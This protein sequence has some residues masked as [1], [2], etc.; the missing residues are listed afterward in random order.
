MVMLLLSYCLFC[1]MPGACDMYVYI[2]MDPYL[3][4]CFYLL[5]RPRYVIHCSLCFALS[6]QGNQSFPLHVHGKPSDGL[7][8]VT[9]FYVTPVGLEGERTCSAC[10]CLY[11]HTKCMRVCMCVCLP[12]HHFNMQESPLDSLPWKPSFT[13]WPTCYRMRGAPTTWFMDRGNW[14]LPFKWQES[15][16]SSICAISLCLGLTV[17]LETLH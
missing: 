16:A 17:T 6:K 7:H 13:T 15:V 5:E 9:L 12:I 3:N 14:Y 1:C 11:A 10:A 4:L 8:V 2:K